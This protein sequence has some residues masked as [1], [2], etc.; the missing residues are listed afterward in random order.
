MK[1]VDNEGKFYDE[2]DEDLLSIDPDEIT[3]SQMIKDC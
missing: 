3:N 1:Y 2:D